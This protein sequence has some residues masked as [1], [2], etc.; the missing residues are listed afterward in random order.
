MYLCVC[1]SSILSVSYLELLGLF[2]KLISVKREEVSAARKRTKTGL[3]KL[4]S[5]GEQVAVLQEE[6]EKMQPELEKAQVC[7]FCGLCVGGWGGLGE[8]V[9][10]RDMNSTGSWATS[11]E[12]QCTLP[13]P[14]VVLMSPRP[15]LLF[16]L[17][18]SLPS[19]FLLSSLSPSPLPC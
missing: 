3:D 12:R 5:T 2:S 10:P 9:S 16:P 14:P 6:L 17:A 4:L 15:S 8:G 13:F 7:V 1:V 19:L 18:L 11:T